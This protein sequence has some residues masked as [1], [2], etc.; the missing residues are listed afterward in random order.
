[1]SKYSQ[2]T[3]QKNT[4]LKQGAKRKNSKQTS[5]GIWSILYSLSD[6]IAHGWFDSITWEKIEVFV[7]Q[8]IIENWQYFIMH[9]LDFKNFHLVSIIF[10]S[11]FKKILRIFEKNQYK[12]VFFKIHLKK[13]NKNQ[14]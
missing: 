9:I 5:T 2:S 12:P 7:I 14:E 11:F 1:M 3:Y 8:Y 4:I 10:L 6:F 13:T